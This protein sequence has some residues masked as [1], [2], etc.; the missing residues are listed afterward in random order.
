MSYSGKVVLGDSAEK[1]LLQSQIDSFQDIV[2][3]TWKGYS[4]FF[5]GLEQRLQDTINEWSSKFFEEWELVQVK[6]PIT[7]EEDNEGKWYVSAS[8]CHANSFE[9]KYSNYETHAAFILKFQ[10]LSIEHGLEAFH[11]LDF[12]Q[13]K[14]EVYVSYL[15]DSTTLDQRVHTAKLSDFVEFLRK[16]FDY[17]K[18]L[19][20]DCAVA[21]E[22]KAKSWNYEVESMTENLHAAIAKVKDLEK[23]ERIQQFFD[24]CEST[25]VFE[26]PR[27]IK[28]SSKLS[29]IA[30]SIKIDLV[31]TNR[32]FVDLNLLELDLTDELRFVE[33]TYKRVFIKTLFGFDLTQSETLKLIENDL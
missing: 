3:E 7:V 5:N 33:K 4:N 9:F 12:E 30:K 21:Q 1:L 27:N 28:V 16:N 22:A 18:G 26:Q 10:D 2:N 32:K 6:W 11:N 13:L 23:K 17:L 20:Q 19:L 31:H 15:D 8:E 25:V 14:F 24:A 29:V